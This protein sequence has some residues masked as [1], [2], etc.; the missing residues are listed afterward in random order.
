MPIG[1]FGRGTESDFLCSV[2]V[3]FQT[4]WKVVIWL[5]KIDNF[6]FH[7]VV[8]FFLALIRLFAVRA[9]RFSDEKKQPCW[10]SFSLIRPVP[11]SR[12]PHL[13][14]GSGWRDKSSRRRRILQFQSGAFLGAAPARCLIEIAWE[15][16]HPDFSSS[17]G[18]K[19]CYDLRH[20]SHFPIA[21]CKPGL[22]IHSM[23][24]H[25]RQRQHVQH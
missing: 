9:S 10:L 2:L 4:R 24:R 16:C 14:M 6:C 11:P 3:V 18:F 8:S 22:C 19:H 1:G 20:Q 7:S 25:S 15:C 17:S 5:R 21:H 12:I 23:Q 13:F